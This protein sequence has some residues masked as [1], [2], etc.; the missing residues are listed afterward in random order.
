[1]EPAI[2]KWRPWAVFGQDPYQV[3][4]EGHWFGHSEAALLT[5]VLRPVL[6]NYG[7]RNDVN[8]I[9]M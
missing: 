3:L 6:V 1:M 4:K 2:D 9:Y 5:A 8:L 7:R